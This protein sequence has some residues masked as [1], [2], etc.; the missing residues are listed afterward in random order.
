MTLGESLAGVVPF[1]AT[2]PFTPNQCQKHKNSPAK[3][4]SPGWEGWLP[5]ILPP[6][7]TKQEKCGTQR[8]GC[9]P[10]SLGF[11]KF[12]RFELLPV[13]FTLSRILW[14]QIGV[15]RTQKEIK[16][17][18]AVWQRRKRPK[19]TVCQNLCPSCSRFCPAQLPQADGRCWAF[20]SAS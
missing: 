19:P 18:D 16:H 6:K 17:P 9:F 5:N 11:A 12:G 3:T 20:G 4:L 13:L 8:I 15:T 10:F 2:V 7:I 1:L 14:V